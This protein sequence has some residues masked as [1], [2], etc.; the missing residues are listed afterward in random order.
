MSARRGSV[1]IARG[2]DY[3]GGE[4]VVDI[5]KERSALSKFKAAGQAAKA[6]AAMKPRKTGLGALYADS[7]SNGAP[8]K[9]KPKAPAAAPEVTGRS[10]KKSLVQEDREHELYKG[11][12]TAA[13]A[14]EPVD[15]PVEGSWLAEAA[16]AAEEKIKEEKRQEK[17]IKEW[18]KEAK[19]VKA[20]P[21][22]AKAYTKETE[23]VSRVQAMA[24]GQSTR[25]AAAQQG[26]SSGILGSIG[27]FLG[28]SGG[29]M[30]CVQVRKS[31][32]DVS[33]HI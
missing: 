10:R 5:Q 11:H 12:L 7:S 3:D 6:Q 28:M 21:D 30:E 29:V 17:R 14:S 22:V 13:A 18:E 8:T 2:E 24:R 1:T 9:P 25:K 15:E 31:E 19:S 4:D 23:A 16:L 27:S 33:S 20:S 32:S 26:E